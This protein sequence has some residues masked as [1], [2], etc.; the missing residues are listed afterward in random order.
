MRMID[1]VIWVLFIGMVI[2]L[3]VFFTKRV[4]KNR[5][6][7]RQLQAELA[8]KK[9]KYRY[10]NKEKL[11]ACP[12]EDLATAV[13]IQCIRKEDENFD[14]YFEKL[15]HAEKIVYGV[16]QVTLTL[17]GRGAS[18]HSFFLSPSTRPYV[19]M[20]EEMFDAIGAYELGDLMKAAKRFAEIIENEEE[21]DEDDPELG[22]YSRYNFS[23]FTNEFATL[24]SSINLTEKLNQ[25]IDDHKEEFYDEEPNTDE[26]SETNLAEESED[27]NNEG[28]SEQI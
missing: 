8:E 26:A 2:F 7:R 15:S 13:V 4:N 9:E 6:L 1:I 24:A 10:L 21:D 17:Q 18:L 27:E 12:K 23:D 22:D 20:T 14:H 16:Y 25:Y 5:A 28:I 19:E 11:D 3:A